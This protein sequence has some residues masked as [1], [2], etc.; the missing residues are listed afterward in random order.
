M[1]QTT[2]APRFAAATKTSSEVSTMLLDIATVLRLSAMVK[3]EMLRDRAEADRK[4][5]E[6]RR[7]SRLVEAATVSA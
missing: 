1:T 6:T 7:T 4:F 3:A 5:V 2:K